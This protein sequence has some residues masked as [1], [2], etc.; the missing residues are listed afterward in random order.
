MRA[1]LDLAKQPGDLPGQLIRAMKWNLH[2]LH[3]GELPDL[4]KYVTMMTPIE[5]LFSTLN[6]E[7]HSTLHLVYPT[8]KV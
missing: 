7:T 2:P 5:I 4:T 3:P 1:Y 6:G 8:L